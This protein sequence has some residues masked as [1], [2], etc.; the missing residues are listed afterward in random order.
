MIE[1]FPVTARETFTVRQPVLRKGR[2]IEDCHFSGDDLGTTF[3]LGAFEKDKIIG[4]ATFLMNK[5]VHL[6][7]IK[8]IKLH[9]CYQLRGM[10]VLEIA[11]GKG[12]GKKILKRAEQI[13]KERNIEVLWFNARVN[14]TAFYEKMDYQ[15]VGNSFDIPGVGEH[16]KMIKK[17]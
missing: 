4:V 1:I 7:Q 9:Y 16:Y 3:H 2:P 15:L 13:L 11:Q 5:D 12:I 10:A 6:E 8:G 17:L 14:A